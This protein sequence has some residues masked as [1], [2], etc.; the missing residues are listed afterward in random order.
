MPHLSPHSPQPQVALL[1][2]LLSK[3]PCLGSQSWYVVAFKSPLTHSD[4]GL[5]IPF[6]RVT[7]QDCWEKARGPSV[8]P[9]DE[10]LGL[11]WAL[12]APWLCFGV[13]PGSLA[14]LL[15]PRGLMSLLG[16]LARPR[17]KACVVL[18]P[19]HLGAI[20]GQSAASSVLKLF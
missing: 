1:S 13:S 15:S 10:H 18:G 11:K 17:S 5:G 3:G 4:R 12:L 19:G 14:L 16:T 7:L 9:P 8:K 20:I 6:P 2:S